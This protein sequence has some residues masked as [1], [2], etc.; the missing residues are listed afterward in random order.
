MGDWDTMENP[1]EIKNQ[2]L[3]ILE[4]DVQLV[5]HALPKF[6]FRFV[7]LNEGDNIL[8]QGCRVSITPKPHPQEETLLEGCYEKGGQMT[9][10]G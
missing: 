9:Y 8:G 5:G 7:L 1:Y 3:T 6:L 2:E 4:K 10:R